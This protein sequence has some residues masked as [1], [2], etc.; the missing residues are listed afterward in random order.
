M[1]YLK[2]STAVTL[3]IGPFIDDTDGKTAETGLTEHPADILLS[4]NGGNFA[5]KNEGTNCSHDNLGWYACPI[6]ATDTNT[7]GRLQLH[8]HE[9]G[10]LPVFHEYM[11]LPAN[12]YNSLVLGSASD[13]LDVAVVEQANID[14]GAL[15]KASIGD[16]VWDE[17]VDAAGHSVANSAALYLRNI[18]QSIVTRIA[19]ATGGANGSIT[20]DVA[21]SAVNDYY[22]GMIIAVVGG[23]GAGQARACYAYNGGTFVASIRPDWATPPNATSWYSILNVGSAVV[24]AIEDIDF[25]ATMKASINAECDTAITDSTIH[26]DVGTV[27][28]NLAAVAGYVDTEVAAIKAS[29]D[30]LTLAA[31]ADAVLDE[32]TE[33]GMTLRKA[34]NVMLAT[35]AGKSSGGGTANHKFRDYA[36]TKD[37]LDETVTAVGNRTAVTLDGA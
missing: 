14:F 28:A 8:C 32:V 33:V 29:T 1:L 19:Q 36:D 9:A 20:L 21:A 17:V 23:A 13:Y 22:K 15:Q 2:Q 6:D 12:V 35:L 31:I 30:A 27:I 25:G 11:V 26:A 4:K 16:A 37:R 10:F 5:A 18:Y 3:K 34:T 7:L 24:A